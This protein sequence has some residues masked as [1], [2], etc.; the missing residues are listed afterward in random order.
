MDKPARSPVLIIIVLGVLYLSYALAVQKNAMGSGNVN[1]PVEPPAGSLLNSA[2]V[3]PGDGKSPADKPLVESAQRTM[4]SSKKAD[5]AYLREPVTKVPFS[6]FEN[7]LCHYAYT[8]LLEKSQA[9]SK[10]SEIERLKVSLKTSTRDFDKQV[11]KILADAEANDAKK[12]LVD[13]LAAIEYMELKGAG[14]GVAPLSQLVPFLYGSRFA[15][16]LDDVE[17]SFNLAQ[18]SMR[19]SRN[20]NDYG[21]EDMEAIY[22]SVETPKADFGLYKDTSREVFANLRSAQGETL[23]SYSE[24]LVKAVLD[25]PKYSYH[26]LNAR[27]AGILMLE[28]THQRFQAID[29]LKSIRDRAR[30]CG[31]ISILHDAEAVLDRLEHP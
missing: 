28:L 13:C 2:E 9:P 4:L 31:D 1:F 25:L 7:S 12:G 27:M 5:L 23:R 16:M 20:A 24:N 17:E 30:E 11:L 8:A 21:L 18:E 19:Y 29:E 3:K 10:V 15:F 22:Y 6:S 14:D 26:M